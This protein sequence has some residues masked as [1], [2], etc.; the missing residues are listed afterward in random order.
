[1]QALIAGN[2]FMVAISGNPH[3]GTSADLELCQLLKM[4]VSG[5]ASH[6]FLETGWSTEVRRG[7]LKA[8]TEIVRY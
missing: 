5:L 8:N 6:V 3:E 1:M 4:V 7:W 2:R